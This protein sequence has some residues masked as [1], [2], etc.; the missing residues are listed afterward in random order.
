MADELPVEVRDVDMAFRTGAVTQQVLHKVSFAIRPGETL[1]LVGESGSGK[2]TM[3]RILVGLYVPTGGSVR[4]F[5]RSITGT[6]RRG[7]LAAVRSRLQFVFQDPHSAL[8][9]RMR[10][11]DSGR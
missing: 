6:E 2:S 7:N 9:P 11:G 5:G 4:L 8:N 3:G 1:G 10:V